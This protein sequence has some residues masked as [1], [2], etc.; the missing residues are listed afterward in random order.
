MREVC[1][2]DFANMNMYVR[3]YVGMYVLYVLSA[4]LYVCM[5][6]RI[7]VVVRSVV[8][9]V[10]LTA[11][12]LGLGEVENGPRSDGVAESR[13][14]RHRHTLLLSTIVKSLHYSVLQ[15]WVVPTYTAPY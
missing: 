4:G 9:V 8:D 7:K 1:F 2:S 5:H 11:V 14:I 6:A 10:L 15:G 12:E 3:M 13:E